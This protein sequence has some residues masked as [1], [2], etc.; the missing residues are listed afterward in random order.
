MQQRAGSPVSMLPHLRTLLEGSPWLTN[1]ELAE[2]LSSIA[3]AVI[4]HTQVGTLLTR[5]LP[6]W[7][8]E[9]GYKL[10]RTIYI[11]GGNGAT[12]RHREMFHPAATHRRDTLLKRLA[13]WERVKAGTTR[14]TP[15]SGLATKMRQWE[16]AR[17]SGGSVIDYRAER[18]PYARLAY[19]WELRHVMRLDPPTDAAERL[20]E[21]I[22]AGEHTEVIPQ[23]ETLFQP[24][25]VRLTVSSAHLGPWRDALSDFGGAGSLRG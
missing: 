22:E 19:P 8:E 4:S 2:R 11:P 16:H 17:L 25:P 21:G 20:R 23:E 24:G 7:E 18:G 9:W 3:G 10:D 6:E 5:F 12:Y 15:D 14:L 13:T 1:Q